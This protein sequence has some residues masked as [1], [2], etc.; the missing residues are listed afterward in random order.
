MKEKKKKKNGCIFAGMGFIG[1]SS[2][3]VSA[4]NAGGPG[5]IPG[6][7]RSPGEG[8]GNPLQYSFFVYLFYTPVFLPG[9]LYGQRSLGGYSPWGHK[10]S[11]TLSDWHFHFSLSVRDLHVCSYT[12]HF[13]A[14]EKEMA[15][16]PSVFAWRTPGTGEPGG[17]LSVGSH[18]VGHDWSD[19]AAAATLETAGF[20]KHILLFLHANCFSS[21]NEKRC[22]FKICCWIIKTF[23]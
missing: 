23:R 7:G 15:T 17:L 21:Q 10:E 20:L 18:R 11:D 5:S 19:L 13:P 4:W 1:G 14:S 2:G 16:H 3:K 9:K 8:N 12:F 6:S 22:I